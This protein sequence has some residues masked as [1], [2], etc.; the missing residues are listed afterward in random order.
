V[1]F[2]SEASDLAARDGD[3]LADVYL[4]DTAAGRLQ[5]I[6]VASDRGLLPGPKGDGASRSPSV[7]GD[8]VL[9]VF[10]S[11]A[12]N[13]LSP[14]ADGNGAVEDVFLRD[15]A[16]RTTVLVSVSSRGAAADAASEHAVISAGAG[17]IAFVSLATN[18]TG[19]PVAPGR[20]R[21]HVATLRR[22]VVESLEL[23]GAAADGDSRAPDISADGR[24]VAFESEATNLDPLDSNRAADV[25]LLDRSL[26]RLEI[27]SLGD[28]RRRAT[29]ACRNPDGDLAVDVFARDLVSGRTERVS[30]GADGSE[31]RS[32][33]Q[34]AGISADGRFV[35]F[36][37]RDRLASFDDNDVADFYVRDRLLGRTFV[38]S[39]IVGRL[40]T[41]VPN[42]AVIAG[43]LS[44]D[45]QSFA[46]AS[47]ATDIL[48]AD[49]TAAPDVYRCVLTQAAQGPFP[50]SNRI[51]LP[52]DGAL[53]QY[54]LTGRFADRLLDLRAGETVRGCAVDD[55]NA[56][57]LLTPSRLR[58]VEALTF[59]AAQE[60]DTVPVDLAGQ[61]FQGLVA[62]G[63]FAYAASSVGVVRFSPE[64]ETLR[65][66]PAVVGGPPPARILLAIAPG[67]RPWAAFVRAGGA[68]LYELT[69]ELHVVHF[70]DLPGAS[71]IAMA[72]EPQGSLL[73]RSDGAV[74]RLSRAGG[75]LWSRVVEGGGGL[76]A[77]GDGS[78]LTASA[79]ALVALRGDGR[80]AFSA[81]L[82]LPLAAGAPVLLAL[83]GEGSALIVQEGS[84]IVQRVRPP[85]GGRPR[86]EAFVAGATGP[87]GGGD[88]TGFLAAN[89][90]ARGTDMD[91][92]GHS[93]GAETAE[94]LNPFDVADPAAAER[95]PAVLGLTATA[96]GGRRVRL[97]WTNPVG[98]RQF[99]VFR[100]GQPIAGSPFPFAAA[101][102]GV[103]DPG[104]PGGVHVYRVIGQGLGGAGGG[105][106]I[107]PSEGLDP[108][109]GLFQEA[110]VSQGEGSVLGQVALPAAPQAVAHDAAGSRSF[111]VLEAGL[112]WTFD[113]DL[114]LVAQEDLPADPFSSLEVRGLAVDQNDAGRPMYL[115]LG[116]GRVFRRT[117]PGA[118]TL[119]RT[120]TGFAPGDGGFTGLAVT[121]GNGND[122]FTTMAGP[123]VDCLIGF[124]RSTGQMQ[125]GAD[126]S[127][128]ATLDTPVLQSL[129]VARIGAG[130]L[131]GAALDESFPPPTIDRIVK[132][133]LGPD[134]AISDA[135][136]SVS[137][138]AL[139][140]DDIAGFDYVPGSGILVADRAGSRLVLLEATF[141]GSLAV[142]AASPAVG[143]WDEPAAGVQI[144]GTGFG[145][146]AADLQVKVD[147]Y[148]VAVKG[149]AGGTITVDIPPLGEAGAVEIEVST[150]ASTAF[151]YPGFTFG[152]VRGDANNDRRVDI[153]DALAVL[154]YL[155]LGSA[156][157]PCLDGA[158]VDDNEAVEI[159]D[160]VADLNF[161]F[162]GNV[163]PAAPFPGP[164]L[165]PAGDAL[166]CGE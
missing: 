103:I 13:L 126:A 98:Y 81:P 29:R 19:S 128:S 118:T 49:R 95:L 48:P 30:I 80:L 133:D 41:G 32:D 125:P 40:G 129:G 46:H 94:L 104:V 43:D 153:S 152:F 145:A 56:L 91:G 151:L 124:F 85:A 101:A 142:L 23:V 28:G 97:E 35:G 140:S 39:A 52:I 1:A 111:A 130:F 148:A 79:T 92:D 72:F 71:P 17:A 4:A 84:R 131:A 74:T 57:W 157:P 107:D 73:L 7:S 165:D 26:D 114:G 102:A 106:L 55:R 123:G 156:A 11:T 147:G 36:L 14:A 24:H 120:L 154:G 62:A 132:L 5:L 54:E 135:G 64:G 42:G 110:S 21:I 88:I 141:P 144:S 25:F 2:V 160:A 116:D 115:L 6:S 143:R 20:R 93:N 67:G 159:T 166:G 137:L 155:F 3:R 75:V 117:G 15:T 138:G 16:A 122:L 59:R 27:V 44:G 22:G 77:A 82:V 60:S 149:L 119:F 86:A 89:V 161:L 139:A 61:T 37:C 96:I 70:R 99:Y 53:R 50:A 18:L 78:V 9:V 83:D 127:L 63:G 10:T 34:L 33:C 146:N 158:D 65:F 90:A 164:G 108:P 12:S 121:S 45:G 136:A 87:H 150:L 162:L 105:G 68:R 163:Q 134:F 51:V 100:D 113:Q 69:R 47:L 66:A 38:A 109:F 8:G 76:I 58:R 112:L 31:T